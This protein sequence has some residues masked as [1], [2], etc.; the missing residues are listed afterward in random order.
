MVQNKLMIAIFTLDSKDAPSEQTTFPKEMFP[1]EF[2][3]KWIV[4]GS[5]AGHLF[6]PES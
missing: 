2:H 4:V 3:E 5:E 6:V 1:F